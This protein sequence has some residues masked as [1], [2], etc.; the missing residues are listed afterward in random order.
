MAA[1]RKKIER[2]TNQWRFY[3]DDSNQ[4][5][6]KYIMQGRTAAQAYRSFGQ[7]GDCIDDARSHGY[8]GKHD[9]RRD[10]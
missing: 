6:W 9:G 4:W 2:S 7:Y 1:G 8:R 3:Q 10:G 5:R